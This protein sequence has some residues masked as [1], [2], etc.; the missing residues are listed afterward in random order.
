MSN[1]VSIIL[2]RNCGSRCVEIPGWIETGN[3][4]IHCH[5]CGNHKELSGFTL[6]RARITNAELQNARDTAA[7][8]GASEK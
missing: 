8:M 5:T 7:R 6:G 1:F 2:C 4:I 3:A